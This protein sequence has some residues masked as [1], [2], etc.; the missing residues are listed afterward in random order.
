[1]HTHIH[2][3]IHICIYAYT[4][5][6]P[7]SWSCHTYKKIVLHM[8]MTLVTHMNESCPHSKYFTRTNESCHTYVSVT[9]RMETRHVFTQQVP[10]AYKRVMSR[11]CMSNC[12]HIWVIATLDTSRPR[13]KESCY[14]HEWVVFTIF[15]WTLRFLRVSRPEK[16]EQK[17]LA[18]KENGPK[19]PKRPQ[20]REIFRN[21]EIE[22]RLF[23]S[24]L[25]NEYPKLFCN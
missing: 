9:W 14:T 20:E 12:T 10:H 5:T 3:C 25:H 21:G 6:P 16:G 23:G 7:V 13:T 17:T 18:E 19:I 2:V 4:R 8:C 22:R 1:M 15:S 24:L 11:I